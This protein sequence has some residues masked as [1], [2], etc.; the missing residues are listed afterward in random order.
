MKPEPRISW[1]EDFDSRSFCCRV[2][3]PQRWL[4]ESSHFKRRLLLWWWLT[5]LSWSLPR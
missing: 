5:K 1:E 2:K 4:M 3:I